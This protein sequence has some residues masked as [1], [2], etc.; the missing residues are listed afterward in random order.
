M[1]SGILNVVVSLAIFVNKSTAQ[2]GFGGLGNSPSC[3]SSCMSDWDS[4]AFWTNGGDGFC[5]N[6]TLIASANSC[7][8]SSSCSASDKESIY[9]NIAQLC[10]S[11]GHSVTAT[12]EATFSV[13]ANPSWTTSAWPG[14]SGAW[15]PGFGPFGGDSGG[16][17]PW[18]SSGSWTTG[19]WTGW[20]GGAGCPGSTWTGWTSGDWDSKA[21]WTSWTACS[22][23]TTATVTFTTTTTNAGVTSV[24]TGTTF[25]VKV[26]EGTA[27]ATSTAHTPTPTGTGGTSLASL[28]SRKYDGM[29]WIVVFGAFA[30]ATVGAMVLL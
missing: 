3:A 17:G 22:A 21:P 27:T 1:Y 5:S 9:K 20:W 29:S 4:G 30:A 6:T 16:W 8:D 23:T 2:F 28:A 13:T 18:G 11:V 15:G 19:A 7:V 10:A 14:S 26:A 12:P 25:G 24:V